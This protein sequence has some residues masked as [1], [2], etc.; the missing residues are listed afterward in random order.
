MNLQAYA[1]QPEKTRIET[2][3]DDGSIPDYQGRPIRVTGLGPLGHRLDTRH[4][5]SLAAALKEAEDRQAIWATGTVA[6][7]RL[8]DHRPD[9]QVFKVYEAYT[10]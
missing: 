2:I 6:V 5:E 1:N 8:D 4:A 7:V 9:H 3:R 10:A